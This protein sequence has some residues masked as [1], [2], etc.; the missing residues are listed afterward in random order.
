[1]SDCRTLY[2]TCK[3]ADEARDI[4]KFLLEEGLIACGNI[5]DK[6]TSIYKWDGKVQEDQEA[7]LILKTTK[8]K[9]E[10]AI[11]AIK[12]RH[13]YDVPCICVWD[14]VDG[15]NEYLEWIKENSN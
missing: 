11:E 12:K 4:C 5:I 7:I 6:A 13:S 10:A 2:V 15:N 9:T 1:M 14:I 3:N 8:E